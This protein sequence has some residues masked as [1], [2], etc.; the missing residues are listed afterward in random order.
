MDKALKKKREGR[1]QQLAR[2]VH[3]HDVTHGE[4][5]SLNPRLSCRKGME[6]TAQISRGQIMSLYAQWL[7]LY[8]SIS[9]KKS[10]KICRSVLGTH[11]VGQTGFKLRNLLSWPH[12]GCDYKYVLHILIKD[13]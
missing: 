1:E 6:K 4:A 13:F 11:Y 3:W 2:P 10:L 7:K 5:A 8:C 9:K 12:K